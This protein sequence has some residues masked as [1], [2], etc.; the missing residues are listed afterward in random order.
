MA[1]CGQ[2]LPNSFLI[3]PERPDF[4]QEEERVLEYWKEIDAFQ[5]QMR[6]TK[7]K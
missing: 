3:V 6:R 7:G 1:I 5:E 4:P 2:F